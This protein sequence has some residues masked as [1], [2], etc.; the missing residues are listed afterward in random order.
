MSSAVVTTTN[1]V[2]LPTAAQLAQK[3]ADI[4]IVLF[5][6]VQNGRYY[7]DIYQDIMD[8]ASAINCAAQSLITINNATAS[9]VG[10]LIIPGPFNIGSQ[11]TIPANINTSSP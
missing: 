9:S 11:A 3:A 6:N 7:G 4:S 8:L 2:S 5:Q 10:T 1:P